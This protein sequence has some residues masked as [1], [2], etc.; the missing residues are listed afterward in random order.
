MRRADCKPGNRDARGAAVRAG[1][2]LAV[3]LGVPG[4]ILFL[5]TVLFFALAWGYAGTSERL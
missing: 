3:C 4:L 5:V 1:M 2:S